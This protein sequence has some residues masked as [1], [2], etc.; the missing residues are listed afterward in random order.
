MSGLRAVFRVGVSRE[1]ANG[2]PPAWEALAREFPTIGLQAAPGA[3]QNSLPS[4]PVPV[5][6][7]ESQ[8]FNFYEVDGRLDALAERDFG[9]FAVDVLGDPGEVAR[10]AGAVLTRCQRWM[11]RRNEASRE[12]LFDRV[13]A[14]HRDAHDLAAR[15][16]IGGG[17]PRLGRSRSRDP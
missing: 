4:L 12:R 1:R 13:L 14:E 2:L 9:P 7:W 5:A 3:L 10:A 17:P 16:R 6:E 8:N 11:D 15:G